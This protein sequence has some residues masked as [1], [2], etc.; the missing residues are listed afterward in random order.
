M[1]NYVSIYRAMYLYIAIYRGLLNC[2]FILQ[3]I[4]IKKFTFFKYIRKFSIPQMYYFITLYI[5]SM[6]PI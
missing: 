5:L 3:T 2:E 1:V 4:D 6:N